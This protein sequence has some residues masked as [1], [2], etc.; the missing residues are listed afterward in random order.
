MPWQ[1]GIDEAGYGP[2]LGPLVMGVV[3]CRVPTAEDLWH[4]MRTAVR[5]QGDKD[6]GRLLVADSKVVFSQSKGLGSLETVVLAFLNGREAEPCPEL[7]ALELDQLVATVCGDSLAEIRRESWFAGTTRLPVAADEAS[8]Q[9]GTERWRGATAECG[10]HWGLTTAVLVAAERFN[11]L[12]DKWGSKGA[13]LG[14]GLTELLRPCVQLPGDDA[15]EI[16][17]DKHGGRN[18]YSVLLQHVFDEGMVLAREEGALRSTY[19]IIGL[20]RPVRVTFMPRAD[21]AAFCVALASMLCKYL[22]EVLM[23]EFNRFWRAKVPGLEPTAGYPGDSRRFYEAIEPEL[24]KLG[25]P[26]ERVWRER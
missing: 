24:T 13:V 20:G 23:G 12:V 19:D 8:L 15:L 14:I 18:H 3:A 7:E 4:H 10:A 2:N 21:A 22:R 16:V 5:R 1:V 6:D 17:V 26:R 9:A 11:A 25:I